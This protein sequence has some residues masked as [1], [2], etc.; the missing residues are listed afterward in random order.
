MNSP[1]YVSRDVSSG[2]RGRANGQT[3]SSAVRQAVSTPDSFS[4]PSFDTLRLLC[5]MRQAGGS[6][7]SP[8]TS[9]THGVTLFLELSAVPEL[10]GYSSPPSLSTGPAPRPR[11]RKLMENREARLGKT[12]WGL[13]RQ[14]EPRARAPASAPQERWP[15]TWATSSQ[16]GLLKKDRTM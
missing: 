13:D 2:S 7:V 1:S 9:V 4:Q 15:P 8:S 11:P 16:S 6:G 3:P 5:T 10:P 14:M 12:P